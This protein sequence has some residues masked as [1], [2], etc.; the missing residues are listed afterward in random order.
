MVGGSVL[1]LHPPP[2]LVVI[3]L[4]KLLYPAWVPV[5]S[6]LSVLVGGLL[7]FYF[8]PA[9]SCFISPSAVFEG[10]HISPWPSS[11][12]F[13]FV[14]TI[15]RRTEENHTPADHFHFWKSEQ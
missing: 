11:S 3:E 12:L 8:K 14:N 13:L 4:E 15:I 6:R 2:N 5:H 1:D 7:R 10:F 9:L